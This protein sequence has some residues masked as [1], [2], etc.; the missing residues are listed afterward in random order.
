MKLSPHNLVIAGNIPII[1]RGG[2]ATRLQDPFNVFNEVIAEL[3][4]R[5]ILDQADLL[6]NE[7]ELN[8][9]FNSDNIYIKLFPQRLY[10]VKGT[11]LWQTEEKGAL[12]LFGYENSTAGLLFDEDF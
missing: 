8:Q 9:M 12:I 7:K 2:M 4:D 1:E 10:D 3:E 11:I 5:D 6:K